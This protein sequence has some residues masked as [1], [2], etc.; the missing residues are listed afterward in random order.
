VEARSKKAPFLFP[1]GQLAEDKNKLEGK[2]QN[3]NALNTAKPP[4]CL[5]VCYTVFF[6]GRMQDKY[7]KFVLLSN[8]FN[9]FC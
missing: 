2:C 8:I 6:K 4:N 5:G 3:I 9:H 1:R 7:Q